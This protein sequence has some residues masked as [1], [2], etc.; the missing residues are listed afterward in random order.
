[1]ISYVQSIAILCRLGKRAFTIA[2][3]RSIHRLC[4]RRPISASNPQ[5][6]YVVEY[7]CSVSTNWIHWT[8]KEMPLMFFVRIY[9][10]LFGVGQIT[11]DNANINES[12]YQQI[13][14]TDL[15]YYETL[16]TNDTHRISTTNTNVTYSVSCCSKMVLLVVAGIGLHIRLPDGLRISN[17]LWYVK[18]SE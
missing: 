3:C 14:Q 17:R 9:T 12:L 10:T 18:Y 11:M 5:R 2:A 1:M 7:R 13:A 4:T 8:K 16:T 15:Y 6:R